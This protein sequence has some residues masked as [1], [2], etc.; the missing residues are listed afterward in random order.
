MENNPAKEWS[1]AIVEWQKDGTVAVVSMNN[2][3][4]RHNLAF[5]QA[6]VKTMDAALADKEVSALVLRSSDAKCWSLGVDLEWLM[7][8]FQ[9]G[10]LDSIKAFLYGMNDVFKKL[11]LVPVPVIAAINGHAFG[12]GAI[13]SCACDFRLMKTDRGYFCFPEV[14][15]GI[16]FL[17]GMLAF[18]KKAMPYDKFNELVLTGRR[19]GAHELAEHHVIEKACADEQALMAE[20]MAYARGFQKKRGIFAEHKRR[21]HKHIMTIIDNEDPPYIESLSLMVQD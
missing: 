18:I 3:E 16:P 4:N 20:A 11:L 1:M 2:G 5:A 15:L 10:D 17:P 9:A 14:D 6:M 7:Q 12:N 8:R 13:L 19:A 21:L